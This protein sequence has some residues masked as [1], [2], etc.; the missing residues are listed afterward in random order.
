[1]SHCRCLAC[2]TYSHARIYEE[3]VRKSWNLYITDLP[4]F[5]TVKVKLSID[6]SILRVVVSSRFVLRPQSLGTARREDFDPVDR[7]ATLPNEESLVSIANSS[8]CELPR[9]IIPSHGQ[10]R[11]MSVLLPA[12]HRMHGL[13]STPSIHDPRPPL[14]PIT[15]SSSLPLSAKCPNTHFN[16]PRP[17]LQTSSV[18]T[19]LPLARLSPRTRPIPKPSNG[20]HLPHVSLASLTPLPSSLPHSHANYSIDY[21]NQPPTSH[22]P[23]P[24]TYPTQTCPTPSIPRYPQLPLLPCRAEN[25]ANTPYASGHVYAP[26]V[27]QSLCRCTLALYPQIPQNTDKA[28]LCSRSRSPQRRRFHSTH[29][30]NARFT[31]PVA[32]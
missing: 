5:L 32:G 10:F 1:M 31:H 11:S 17:P 16:R 27:P 13:H 18:R 12:G 29:T 14:P 8:S 23:T 2:S 25:P 21:P 6:F 19:S 20:V 9:S 24:T 30:A 22:N 28:V 4:S 3:P 15:S 7:V 26:A